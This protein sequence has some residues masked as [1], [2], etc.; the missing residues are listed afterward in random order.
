MSPPKGERK[1]PMRNGILRAACVIMAFGFGS[2]ASADVDLITTDACLNERLAQG[3]NP[4]VCVDQAHQR[5]LT[6]PGDMSASAILCFGQAREAWNIGIAAKMERIK[7]TADERL[8]TIAAVELKYD[9]LGNLM[10]CD[11]MEELAKA[12]S[13]ATGDQIARQRAQ[14]E[15]SAAGLVYLR[16]KLRS[17]SLQ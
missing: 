8:A 17:R 4:T 7:E 5:C 14:C 9:M 13:E 10:Q 6:M 11:R 1:Q 3:E 12:A 2:G 16:V 15:A